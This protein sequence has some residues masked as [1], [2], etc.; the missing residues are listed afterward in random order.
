MI[1]TKNRIKTTI[2]QSSTTRTRAF[3]SSNNITININHRIIT[4]ISI[5]INNSN[6]IPRTKTYAIINM[7]PTITTRET[8]NK[9]KTTRTRCFMQI[10]SL[11]RSK[12]FIKNITIHPTFTPSISLHPSTKSKLIYVIYRTCFTRINP[13]IHTIKII[14]TINLTHNILI[15]TTQRTTII[16]KNS[17]INMYTTSLIKMKN[18]N[19]I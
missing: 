14:S 7:P 17:G 9:R 1:I 4:H 6:M 8:M 5:I 16:T 15:N 2:R 11:P 12:T 13:I 19:M 10:K 18:T 3:N